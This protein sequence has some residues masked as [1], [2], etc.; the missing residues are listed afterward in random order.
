MSHRGSI[1]PRLVA[2]SLVI[3][4]LACGPKAQP[5]AAPAPA[6]AAPSAKQAQWALTPVALTTSARLVVGTGEL[7]GSTDGRRALRD[8]D[9]HWHTATSLVGGEIRAIQRE[10]SGDFLF[11]IDDGSVQV[12]HEPLGPIVASRAGPF[13][14]DRPDHAALLA[15]AAAGVIALV[16]IGLDGH[17]YRSVDGGRSWTALSLPSVP[18][19]KGSVGLDRKGRGLA[20][21]WPQ[22]AY[23]TGDDGATWTRI[24]T[25]GNAPWAVVFDGADRLWLGPHDDELPMAVFDPETLR[26]QAPGAVTFTAAPTW[27]ADEATIDEPVVTG[28]LVVRKI[29]RIVDSRQESR[30][31]LVGP[32]GGPW[33]TRELPSPLWLAEVAGK[34]EDL[35]LSFGEPGG[36]SRL[37]HS[38]DGGATF[39]DEGSFRAL[40][41][42]ASRLEVVVGPSH[43]VI[44][45]GCPSGAGSAACDAPV[46]RTSASGAFTP[47]HLPA[48][49]GSVTHAAIDAVKARLW[50]VDH[51]SS[52]AVGPL[53]DAGFVVQPKAAKTTKTKSTK[54]DDDG[55]DGNDDND[56]GAFVPLDQIE[57]KDGDVVAFGRAL[58]WHLEEGRPLGAPMSLPEGLPA[59]LIGKHGLAVGPWTSWETSDAGAHWGSVTT[60]HAYRGYDC[61]AA[62]CAFRAADRLGWDE[63][64]AAEIAKPST[65]TIDPGKTSTPPDGPLD[66]TSPPLVDVKC[67]VQGKP[68]P[69]TGRPTWIE[70]PTLHWGAVAAAKSGALALVTGELDGKVKSTALLGPPPAPSSRTI[71]ELVRPPLVARFVYQGQPPAQTMGWLLG[72]GAW[73]AEIAW[74][75]PQTGAVVHHVLH[76][77]RLHVEEA[78]TV[79]PGGVFLRDGDLL[80][81]L[82]DDGTERLS[83]LPLGSVVARGHDGFVS[84]DEGTARLRFWDG[85]SKTARVVPWSLGPALAIAS[86]D[87]PF[88]QFSARESEAVVPLLPLGVDPPEPRFVTKTLVLPRC[89]PSDGGLLRRASS[90]SSRVRVTITTDSLPQVLVD[91]VPLELLRADG[92]RC[93]R[94]FESDTLLLAYTATPGA[95]LGGA[96]VTGVSDYGPQPM[97][98]AQALICKE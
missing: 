89:A 12:S 45:L 5:I 24:P 92:T 33:V 40:S 3:I 31:L 61:N 13:E 81:F 50:L 42:A 27:H 47:L 85:V 84:F 86:G 63:P 15:D 8:G 4:G 91:A 55:N 21:I 82:A 77:D 41:G 94:G 57:A 23:A 36:S 14:V 25:T 2:G 75:A 83:P 26:V 54:D 64:L 97:G 88:A 10:P 93:L 87:A 29:A 17:G 39:R 6:K 52:I 46:V 20:L 22:R 48:D 96:L 51:R 70:A 43:F 37:F 38:L 59:Q 73:N 80:R 34:D 56:G 9:G 66:W 95:H 69:V 98:K 78:P 60:P 7:I 1:G 90:W 71:A 49:F 58:F 18:W 68:T 28:S 76:G 44:V 79:F 67:V 53:G 35:W 62:G 74:V 32:L 19:G 11:V 30:R 16:E 65:T 72:N